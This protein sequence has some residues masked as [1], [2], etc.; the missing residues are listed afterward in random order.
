MRTE[1][2]YPYGTED[3]IKIDDL[4]DPRVQMEWARQSGGAE[5]GRGKRRRKKRAWKKKQGGIKAGDYEPGSG[6]GEGT[7]R[8]VKRLT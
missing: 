5:S 4:N 3:D 2:N 8:V 7:A 6:G 1:N